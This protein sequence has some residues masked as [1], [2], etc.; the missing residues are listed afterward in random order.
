MREGQHEAER[1][2]RVT[3]GIARWVRVCGTSK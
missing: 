2:E 1:K 3:L